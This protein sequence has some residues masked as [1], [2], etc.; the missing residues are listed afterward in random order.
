MKTGTQYE[1][2]FFPKLTQEHVLYENPALGVECLSAW[3]DGLA[4]P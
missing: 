3:L 4:C 2:M 1:E